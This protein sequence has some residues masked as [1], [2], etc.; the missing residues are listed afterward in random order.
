M[1]AELFSLRGSS[2]HAFE[3]LACK[4]HRQIS[5]SE[6]AIGAR[7]SPRRRTYASISRI[8]CAIF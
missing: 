4:A 3:G 2:L 1:A 6:L 7:T 8:L 5:L